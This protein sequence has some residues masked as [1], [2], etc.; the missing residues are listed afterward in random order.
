MVKLTQIAVLFFGTILSSSCHNDPQ[1][2]VNLDN[3]VDI[4]VGIE[5]G[6]VAAFNGLIED[7][8]FI[9]LETS[10]KSLIGDIEKI[11]VL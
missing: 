3:L 8:R 4:D 7:V 2:P 10:E 11:T 9:P 1:S 5:R 6:E